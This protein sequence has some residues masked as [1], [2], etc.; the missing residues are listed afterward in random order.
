MLF[1]VDLP[2]DF[3]EVLPQI[4]LNLGVSIEE[5]MGVLRKYTD[6]P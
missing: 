3:Q 5:V 6:V 4:V 1:L 2:D